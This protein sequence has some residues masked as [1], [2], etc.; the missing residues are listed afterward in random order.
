MDAIGGCSMGQTEQNWRRSI[1]TN[2]IGA[3]VVHNVTK[4]ISRT[5]CLGIRLGGAPFVNLLARVDT[6]FVVAQ[7]KTYLTLDTW[8]FD[9]GV[10]HTRDHSQL[11][12]LKHCCVLDTVKNPVWA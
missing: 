11:S 4:P 12:Y 5:Q 2:S 7:R 9:W 8:E 10:P 6:K 1:L 3:D